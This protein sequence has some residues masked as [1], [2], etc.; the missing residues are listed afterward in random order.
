MTDVLIKKKRTVH[1]NR[2][3]QSKGYEKTEGGYVKIGAIL[4]QVK[5]SQ[6]PR[7]CKRQDH[8][9]TS[10]R[11]IMILE[12][13][14]FKK[15]S[16]L[17]NCEIMH[18]YCSKSCGLQHFEQPQET[19]AIMI[20][21]SNKAVLIVLSYEH[22]KGTVLFISDDNSGNLL[23]SLQYTEQLGCKLIGVK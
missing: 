20:M 5:D 16:R 21:N 3:A 13:T 23:L 7:S 6:A 12:A 18:F 10:F 9:P 17:Q 11:A 15:T 4:P 8:C 14:P 1:R 19:N 22:I 2:H